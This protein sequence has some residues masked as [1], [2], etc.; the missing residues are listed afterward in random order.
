MTAWMVVD[1]YF[2]TVCA[3]L[4]AG[5]QLKFIQIVRTDRGYTNKRFVLISIKKN[6]A[7][8]FCNIVARAIE[9]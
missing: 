2:N 7:Y 5:I 8:L 4:D 6:I 1:K 9:R 3:I